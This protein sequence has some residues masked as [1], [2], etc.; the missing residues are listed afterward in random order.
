M[1]VVSD[2][3]W[4]LVQKRTFTRWCNTYLL[5]KS[6]IQD[7]ATDFSDGV[8][9]CHLLEAI[10]KK[11]LPK[12]NTKPKIKA[13]KLE[14]VSVGLAFLKQEGIRLVSIGPE[15]LVEPKLKLIL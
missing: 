5:N 1:E 7:L 2:G 6:P 12:W 13:Q 9:F 8:A 15:D 4:V 3:E 14:N 11:A 10:S